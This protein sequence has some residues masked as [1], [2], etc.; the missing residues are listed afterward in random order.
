MTKVGVVCLCAVVAASCDSPSGPSSFSR[1]P[2]LAPVAAPVPLADIRVTGRVVDDEGRPVPDASIATGY[3]SGAVV[4]YSPVLS[5]TDGT[6][7]FQVAGW[8]RGIDVT[9]AKV[10][11]EDSQLALDWPSAQPGD[12]V[13]T[14]L[15][16]HAIVRISAGESTRLPIV[17]KRLQCSLDSESYPACRSVRIMTERAGRLFVETGRPFLMYLGGWASE[18]LYVDLDAPREVIVQVVSLDPPPQEATIATWLE[19]R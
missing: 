16:L 6:F 13:T 18:R 19:A 10:G 9:V 4:G 2:R 15:P 12:T 7:E 8:S 5:S 1:P 3:R 17:D 11:F 14:T